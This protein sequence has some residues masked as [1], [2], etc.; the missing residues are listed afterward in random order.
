M[1]HHDIFRID[2]FAQ[3]LL[4]LLFMMLLLIYLIGEENKFDIVRNFNAKRCINYLLT[5]IIRRMLKTKNTS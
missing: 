2:F 3:T 5:R 4:L 1:D